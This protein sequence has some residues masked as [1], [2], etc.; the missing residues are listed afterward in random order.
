MAHH[1]ASKASS[2]VAPPYSPRKRLPS[3]RLNFCPEPVTLLTLSPP[4]GSLHLS[5][6]PSSSSISPQPTCVCQSWQRRRSRRSR[7]RAGRRNEH[8]QIRHR[9]SKD[10]T[11]PPQSAQP[12]LLSS[13]KS[14][15][16]REREKRVQRAKTYE[17]C[18]RK[19]T[20]ASRCSSCYPRSRPTTSEWKT[21]RRSCKRNYRQPLGAL[22]QIKDHPPPIN[23]VPCVLFHRFCL[24]FEVLL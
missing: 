24:Y 3:G 1:Q 9:Q 13:S 11:K 5:S 20:Q 23:R 19:S 22:N 18:R 21:P 14:E 6:L 10:Y 16:E 8:G 4:D 7:L 2:L 12:F 17:T 15:R